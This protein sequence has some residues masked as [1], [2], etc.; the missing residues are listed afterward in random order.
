GMVIGG[1][2]R[3]FMIKLAANE[4]PGGGPIEALIRLVT[5]QNVVSE[6]EPGLRTDV[7]KMIDGALLKCLDVL[8]RIV[9]DFGQFG[10]ADYVAYGF[11]ISANM[12]AI[13]MLTA[14]GYFLPVFLA[15]CLFLKVREVAR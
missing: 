2:F 13:R 4:I 10:Y 8:I 7:A 15:G 6:M 1:L 14:L 11:D 5:Q 12:L 9:P 3:E